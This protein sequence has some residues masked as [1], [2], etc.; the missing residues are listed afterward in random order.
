MSQRLSSPE[1]AA[2]S[3]AAFLEIHSLA[4][5]GRVLLAERDRAQDPERQAILWKQFLD[6]QEEL[7]AANARYL[8]ANRQLLMLRRHREPGEP[9]PVP[10]TPKTAAGKSVKR[11]R[12]G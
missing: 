5:E 11:A 6:L 8:E 10:S 9:L 4:E 1:L 3:S 2:A 7:S 12:R